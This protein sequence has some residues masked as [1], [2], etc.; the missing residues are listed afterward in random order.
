MLKF[1]SE[2]SV[3]DFDREANALA[4]LAHENIVHFYGACVDE[5]PWKM[6]FE[7][8]ENGDLNHFLRFDFLPTLQHGF[9]LSL[10]AIISNSVVICKRLFPCESDDIE[11]A[12]PCWN[13]KHNGFCFL[14]CTGHKDLMLIS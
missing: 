4:S 1:S 5:S 3:T 10:T 12:L 8:M 7:Y 13:T 9:F 6:I 2:N 14:N 11:I